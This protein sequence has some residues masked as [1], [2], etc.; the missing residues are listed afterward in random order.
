MNKSERS[1]PGRRYIIG[2]DQDWSVVLYNLN[3]ANNVMGEN[4]VSMP[5]SADQKMN[6]AIGMVLNRRCFDIEVRRVVAR[7]TT[8]L[9]NV[10]V[11]YEQAIVYTVAPDEAI[12][13]T[14]TARISRVGINHLNKL[15]GKKPAQW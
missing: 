11:S 3:R 15:L 1:A 7:T 9:K 14:A 13:A 2:Y 4:W 5:I 8:I 6:W 10:D 12:P